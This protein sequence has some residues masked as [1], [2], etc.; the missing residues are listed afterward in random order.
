MAGKEGQQLSDADVAEFASYHNAGLAVP[1]KFADVVQESTGPQGTVYRYATAEEK[2]TAKEQAE[3]LQAATEQHER[4]LARARA[5]AIKAGQ[6]ADVI[7]PKPADA[8]P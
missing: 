3:A 1:D 5:E 4:F 8:K 6:P 2:R 7:P